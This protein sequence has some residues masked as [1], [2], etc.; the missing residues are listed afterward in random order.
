[1]VPKD[2][3][4]LG[5]VR[6]AYGLKGWVRVAPFADDGTV[7][8]T[9]HHWWLM[10]G[11]EPQR[12]VTQ[13][14]KRHADAMVAKWDGCDSKEVAD[15]LKG[16]KIAVSRSEFPQAGEGEHYLSDVIG[17]RVV[18]RQGVELGTVSGLR[19]GK[20]QPHGTAATQ[21]LEVKGKVEQRDLGKIGR[22]APLLIPLV[23]QY[24]DVIEPDAVKVDWEANW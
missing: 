22:T 20:A 13:G 24:V 5:V 1:M 15:A 19:S 11:S 3:I 7:L 23:E 6:G 4:E 17:R 16:T 18:N 9:V 10:R 12:L 8:E 2:L 14:V 21:W